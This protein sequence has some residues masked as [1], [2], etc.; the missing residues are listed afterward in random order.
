MAQNSGEKMMRRL[1]ALA[2][3]MAVAL[4]AHTAGAEP[5]VPDGTWLVA[6][7]VAFD[8]FPCNHALCGKITWLRNPALR[9][10]EMCGRTII[11]GLTSDGPSQWN[12][13][14][15]LDPENGATYNV[16]AHVDTIDRISARI[17]RGFSVFGRTE[18]LKRISAHSLA[19]WCELSR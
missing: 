4:F 3:W 6:D 15:F 12:D 9:T 2:L 1:A 11:W 19:G 7:R 8:I 18:I 5:P 10:P 16:S 13:G 14:W 17:Y